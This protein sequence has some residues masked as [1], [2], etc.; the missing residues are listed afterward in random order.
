MGDT[1]TIGE[2]SRRAGLRPSALRYYEQLGLLD[3]PT[4]AG[5]FRRYDTGVFARLGVIRLAQQ[6]GFTMAEIAAL[7]H[8]FAPDTPPAARWRAFAERKL[9]EVDA[10]IRR[11]ET[12]R[13]L[14]EESLRCGCLTLED[15]VA[16]LTAGQPDGFACATGCDSASSDS[17]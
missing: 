3:A 8:G 15:C 11:A 4:R 16:P 14:L 5:R 9:V 10:Q 2:V 7:L 6:A 1:L 17:P 13:R 12:M